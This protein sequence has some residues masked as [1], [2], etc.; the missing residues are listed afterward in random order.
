MTTDRKD[1]IAIRISRTLADRIVSGALAP[2]APLRQDHF[3]EEFATSHV[4]VREAFRLL[5][6]QGL[7]V[8]LPRRCFRVASFER[9]EVQEVAEMRAALEA[10]AL[11]HAAPHLTR[12][13]L[14]RAEETIRTGE[15]AGN[16]RD[17]EA[18]NRTF[19]RLIIE[20]CGMPRLLA[21]V[22]DLQA[23][24]TRILFAGWRAQW[25]ARTDSD[26]R[27]ILASLRRGDIDMAASMLARHIQKIGKLRRDG[28]SGAGEAFV[29]DD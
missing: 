2:D 24:S 5:E 11:R 26:H 17:W 16:V 1:T 22:D 10:L 25:E 21:A 18:A 8:S 15:S 27:A 7:A 12:A 23:V 4:P 29:I 19:H 3:A 20:P 6:A 14:D 9:S 13:I 28:A